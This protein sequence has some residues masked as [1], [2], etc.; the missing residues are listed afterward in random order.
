MKTTIEVPE[1]LYRRAKAEA[2]LRGRRVRDLVE[3]GLRRVLDDPAVRIDRPR[4]SQ[5]MKGA[6]G[7]MASGIA[8]LGSNPS[9][10][11]GFGRR[12]SRNR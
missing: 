7:V 5:L 10:L 8:D 6:R 12:A 4:L 3:D 1:E 2:A 9:H 11:S